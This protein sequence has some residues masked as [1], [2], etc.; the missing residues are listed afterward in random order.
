MLP[1]LLSLLLADPPAL[2]IPKGAPVRLDGRVEEPEWADATRIENTVR[3]G[4]KVFVLLKRV[5]GSLALACGADRDYHGETVRLF[6]ADRQGA[7]VVSTVLGVGIPHLPPVLWRRGPP[8]SINDRAAECP[9]GCLVRI[10]VRDPKAWQAE[11]LLSLGELGIGLGDRREF[12]ALVVMGG[13]RGG[14]AL[15][16]PKGVKSYLDVAEYATLL[17][18]DGW[19]AGEKVPPVDPAASREYDDHEL[20]FRLFEEHERISQ[21]S[22]PGRIIIWDAVHQRSTPRIRLLRD[23]LEEGRKRNPTLL[24]WT[25]FL[26][27]LYQEGNFADDAKREIEG[28]PEH[29]RSLQ[30]L[31]MLDA[32]QAFDR[33]EPDRA[34]AACERNPAAP[35]VATMRMLAERLKQA[36]A[37][38]AAARAADAQK[39]ERLPRVVIRTAKGDIECELFEDDAPNAVANFVSLVLHEKYYDRLKFHEAVGGVGVRTGDPRSRIAGG[40][41]TDGPPF[42]LQRDPPKRRALRGALAMLPE[43]S[44]HLHGSQFT[45]AVA[46]LLTDN[47]AEALEVFGR[48]TKGIEVVDS[49]DADDDILSI[50]VIERRN[51]TY[52][53]SRARIR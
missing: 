29:L 16:F 18:P 36:L 17:S 21:R 24:S 34:L 14:E 20:L 51:H 4:K 1:L 9:R 38:E 5:G 7:W 43:A 3:E 53:A 49:L 31:A 45:I 8:E 26:G 6:V 40:A 48:V 41:R 37:E 22:E 10:D 33:E 28:V 46:P 47:D 39:P 30:A 13:D 19:G 11:Y 35:G 12:R 32:E 52:D 23:Q 27:R 50:E 42:K 2:T 25:Y 44:G 15:A